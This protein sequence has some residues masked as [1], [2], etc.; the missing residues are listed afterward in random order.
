MLRWGDLF[1][2]CIVFN[3]HSKNAFMLCIKKT[4]TR[5]HWNTNNTSINYLY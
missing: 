1:S 4:P 2:M 3:Q 5:F